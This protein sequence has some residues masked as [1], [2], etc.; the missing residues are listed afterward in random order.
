[1]AQSHG[2]DQLFPIPDHAPE[3]VREV[4]DRGHHRASLV[5]DGRIMM[6]P[7]QVPTNIENTMRRVDADINVDVSIS[8]DI[9]TEK[10][11]M[12]TMG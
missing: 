7:S 6:D 12:V 2:D 9:A 3:D 10:E 1:M 4:L 8:D 11:L 5:K